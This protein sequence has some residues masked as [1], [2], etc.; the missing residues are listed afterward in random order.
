MRRGDHDD[1]IEAAAVACRRRGRALATRRR[2]SITN[3]V[4]LG[5]HP[6]TELGRRYRDVL[7]RVNQPWAPARRSDAVARRRPG[8]A[9]RRPVAAASTVTLAS[10]PIAAGAVT[11]PARRPRPARARAVHERAATILRPSGALAWL[12]ELAEWVAGWHRTD[13]PR[14]ERPVGLIFAGDHGVAAAEAVSAYPT[15]VTAA[16]FAAYQQGR[17][18]ISAF[19]RHAGATVD[20]V[21]VGIGRPTGDIRFEAALSPE[22]F[23]EIVGRRRRR[24]RPPRRRPARRRRDGHR[25]HDAVGGAVGRARRRRDGG[26]GRARHRRRRRRPGPQAGRRAA[27]GAADR[28]GDRPDRGAARGRRR[29]AG[30]H[31]RRGRRRPPPVAARRARRLRRHV[32]GA[33]TG[34]DRADGARPLHRRPLL[35]RARPPPPARA[36]RQAPAA[37]PRHAPR[38]GQRGDGRRPARGHGLR[39]HH[40]GP[41][42]RGVVRCS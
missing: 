25:Q 6:E 39:R 3:E 36:A 38:R 24:R 40:R 14:V 26:V 12:D 32:V 17:S 18:T 21:D 13:R 11:L 5:V 4:G 28:R 22:R 31:R 27:G 10:A 8:A 41:D 42:V 35:G 23:E 1:E 9:P 16:M 33:A 15:E 37:R 20:A 29:R 34:D 30:G 2:W 19:A 7:G